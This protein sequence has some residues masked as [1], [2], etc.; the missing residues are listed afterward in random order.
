MTAFPPFATGEC[1]IVNKVV[2][3]A[4]FFDV[5]SLDCK[6]LD[7]NCNLRGITGLFQNGCIKFFIW[8]IQGVLDSPAGVT[9]MGGAIT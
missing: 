8:V 6:S 5:K 9:K 1:G 3:L 2:L 4:G 7:F